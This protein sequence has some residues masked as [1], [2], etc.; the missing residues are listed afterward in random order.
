VI[1]VAKVHLIQGQGSDARTACGATGPQVTA[2]AHDVKLVTCVECNRAIG[3]IHVFEK[4]HLGVAPFRFVGMEKKV[5]QACPGAPIQPGGMCDYCGQGIMF[6]CTIRDRD[7][8]TFIVGS[9]C[10]LRT[11]DGNLKKVLG[12][13]QRK[14]NR[15][16]ANVRDQAVRDALHS[17]LDDPETR[18]KLD[19]YRFEKRE[20]WWKTATEEIT[21][22]LDK[23]GAAGRKATLTWAKRILDTPGGV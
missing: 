15:E 10:V 16:K 12:E 22:M 3:R 11:G 8:K 18:A 13:E 7:G 17:L 2:A 9:D 4:A 21:W 19:A 6:L 5:Y 20:G 23:A 1:R 14:L